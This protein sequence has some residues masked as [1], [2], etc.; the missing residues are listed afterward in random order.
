MEPQTPTNSQPILY[1]ALTPISLPS[2]PAA[3]SLPFNQPPLEPYTVFRNEISL[4]P[5]NPISVDSAAPDYFSLDVNEPDEPVSVQT[6][7]SAWDEPE[8]KTPGIV[9]EPR[10]ENKWWFRGNSRF[11]SPML[12][13]HKGLVTI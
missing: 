11:K 2:S 8:L 5:E 7:V 3:E 10:L 4:S 6:P 9:D 1:E 12:Q 13:L